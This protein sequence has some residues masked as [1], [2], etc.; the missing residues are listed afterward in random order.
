MRIEVVTVFTNRRFIYLFILC[1]NHANFTI[2]RLHNPIISLSFLTLDPN[3][4][5]TA[6]S[7]LTEQHISINSGLFILMIIYWFI[8]AIHPDIPE[9]LPNGNYS[10]LI[11]LAREAKAIPVFNWSN[12]L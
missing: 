4:Y 10:T 12:I 6:K 5:P 7:V 1:K 2:I 11:K 8:A 3:D 9:P